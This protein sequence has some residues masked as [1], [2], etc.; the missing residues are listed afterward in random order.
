LG[1]PGWLPFESP[2]QRRPVSGRFSEKSFRASSRVGVGV[3][4]G[5]AGSALDDDVAVLND[6]L[7]GALNDDLC[8]AFNDDLCGAFNDVAVLDDGSTGGGTAHC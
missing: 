6:D 1:L 5:F 3:R 2:D 4:K 7:C 8:G